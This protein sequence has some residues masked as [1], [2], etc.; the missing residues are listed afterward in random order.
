MPASAP[1]ASLASIVEP[2]SSDRAEHSPDSGSLTPSPA[3]RHPLR[4]PRFLLIIAAGL[5]YFISIGMLLPTLP[6]YIANDLDG[7]EVQVGIVMGAFGVAAACARP[8]VGRLGD[9]YGRRAL[10][11]TGCLL[12]A[13][14]IWAS[15]IYL[16]IP[17][18]ILFRAVSG[19]GETGAFVGAATAVQDYAPPHRRAETASYFSTAVYLGMGLGP[20]LGE[21]L[22]SRGGFAMVCRVAALC[23]LVAAMFGMG[24]P[25]NLGRRGDG[26]PP[27]RRG[28]LHPGSIG[29]GLVM[30]ASLLGFI[31]FSAFIALYLDDLTGDGN[32]GPVFLLYSAIILV[33][34]VGFARIPDRWGS[35]RTGTLACVMTFSGLGLLAL[36]S[37][38]TAVYIG[39]AIMAMGIAWGYPAFF[40]LVMDASTDEERSHAVSSFSFF[41]DLPNAFAAPLFG[42]IIKLAGTARAGFAVGAAFALVSLWGLRRLTNPVESRR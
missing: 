40:L 15:P 26:P 3:F 12:S 24:V 2:V 34:R 37:T 29:P 11:V 14:A 10:L 1:N 27:P 18:L 23:S 38:V 4:N 33:L 35:R 32:T 31:A 5:G 21:S 39:T 25:K 42:L 6:R 13:L 7:S 19:L 16:S 28:L 9:R 30:S 17:A 22:A 41:F 20:L 36:S 8:F